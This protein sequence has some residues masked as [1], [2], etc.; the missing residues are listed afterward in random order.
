MEKKYLDKET[1]EYA[2]YAAWAFQHLCKNTKAGRIEAEAF[3]RVQDTLQ[4]HLEH[5]DVEGS[6][7]ASK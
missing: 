5:L 1:L 3:Q 2:I 6:G 4:Y 7:L